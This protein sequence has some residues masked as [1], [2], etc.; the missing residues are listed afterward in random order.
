M[1]VFELKGVPA[2]CCPLTETVTVIP[3]CKLFSFLFCLLNKTCLESIVKFWICIA[4]WTDS[5]DK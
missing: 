5:I 2:K 4:S 3:M 1:V